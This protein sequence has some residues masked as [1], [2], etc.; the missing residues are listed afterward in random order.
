MLDIQ[1]VV[2]GRIVHL[3]LVTDDDDGKKGS[4][5]AVEMFCRSGVNGVADIRVFLIKST[6][7]ELVAPPH[8]HH[9]SRRDMPPLAS[10]PTILRR[11]PT[12]RLFWNYVT[13]DGRGELHM[14][15]N[16]H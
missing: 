1:A 5:V 4:Q 12:G 14:V 9:R 16:K 15:E 8:H 7:V 13:F 10:I 6:E 2:L 3:E 11:C